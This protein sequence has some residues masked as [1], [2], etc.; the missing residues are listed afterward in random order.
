M[1][2]L[3]TITLSIGL[4]IP[5]IGWNQELKPVGAGELTALEAQGA[6]IVDIRT[7]PEWKAS[8][9][10]P[11]S[12]P[13]TFYAPDGRF[14]LTAFAAAV[15][16]LSADSKRPV[17]LVCRSGHRS[18]EAGQLLANFWPERQVLHLD[19]GIQEWIREGRPTVAPVNR[20]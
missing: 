14:D 9:I 5:A 10:I 19:K 7:A 3:L 16:R 4:M 20:P 2:H 13:L 11:G 17:L 18:A 6:L 12:Y 8:G 1:R 15:S